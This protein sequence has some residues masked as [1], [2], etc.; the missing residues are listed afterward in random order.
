[1]KKILS[2]I[3]AAATVFSL[4]ACGAAAPKAEQPGVKPNEAETAPAEQTVVEAPAVET[5]E[6]AQTGEFV[7]QGLSEEITAAIEDA[8]AEINNVHPGTAGS[9]LR[10]MISVGKILDLSKLAEG[11]DASEFEHICRLWYEKNLTDAEL[12]DAFSDSYLAVLEKV[13]EYFADPASCAGL[14]EDCGYKFGEAYSNDAAQWILK[15]MAIGRAEPTHELM[16]DESFIA[17]FLRAISEVHPGTAGSSLRT[18]AAAARVLDASVIADGMEA[19]EFEQECR[20]W[21]DENCADE[22]AR[23]EFNKGF[24]AVSEFA[25]ELVKDPG[26]HTAEL[27]ECGYSLIFGEGYSE[28]AVE[29]VLNLAAIAQARYE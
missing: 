13:G 24:N 25:R 6:A 26:A 16:L 28:D 10:A 8:L 19:P 14:I 20:A 21:I 9:S 11:S 3:I 5:A 23:A 15:Y 7:Y 18:T 2:L 1:M 22:E 29:W 4:C 12:K 27:E 17:A